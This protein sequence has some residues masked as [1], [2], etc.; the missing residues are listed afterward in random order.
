M[1]MRSRQEYL[2]VKWLQVG[3]ERK[4]FLGN[5]KT[6]EVK[7]LLNTLKTKRYICFCA[8][9]NQAE[10]LGKDFCIHSERKDSQEVIQAV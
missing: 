8:S 10:E 6:E 2:K 5:I 3:S 4:R 9:I 7:L 1:Y